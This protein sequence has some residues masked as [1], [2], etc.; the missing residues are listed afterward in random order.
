MSPIVFDTP[1]EGGG[2][3]APLTSAMPRPRTLLV[4]GLAALAACTGAA[5]D[6]AVAGFSRAE[7][8]TRAAADERPLCP[9]FASALP[10]DLR[11][12]VD[13][14]DYRRKVIAKTYVCGE[15][16][17]ATGNLL[18]LWRDPWTGLPYATITCAGVR[19]GGQAGVDPASGVIP[20]LAPA[21]I[22]VFAEDA[23]RA[24]TTVDW[25]FA[26]RA[27]DGTLPTL[28]WALRVTLRLDAGSGSGAS[29]RSG[30]IAWRAKADISRYAELRIRYR[31]SEAGARWRL[32]LASGLG[33]TVE[34]AVTLPGS[35]TWT[36]R[37]F[38]IAG[39]FA[40]T[41]ASHLNHVVFA[42]TLAD[43]GSNPTLWV[44]QV[45][46]IAAPQRAADCAIACPSPSPAYPDLACSEPQTSVA[47]IANALSFLATA[48]EGG[49]LDDDVAKGDVLRIL[50][51]LAVLPGGRPRGD[52]GGGWF[53]DL[54]SPASLMPDPRQRTTT[55]SAQ[56][57]LF[58]ALMVVESTWPDLARRAGALR[59]RMDWSSFYDGRGGCP[60]RLRS[61][62]DR[63]GGPTPDDEAV[64]RLGTDQVLGVFLAE[65]THAAPA[66]YWTSGLSHPA[67]DLHGPTDAPWYAASNVCADG[68]IP[69]SEGGGP[70]RSLAGLLYLQSDRIPTGGLALGASAANMLR[71]QYRFA[72]DN[73]LALAGWSDASDPDACAT[74]SCTGFVPEKVTAYPSAMAASDAFPETYAMLRAFHLLGADAWLNTGSDIISLGLHDGFDQASARA[75]DSYRY[76][77]TGFT[78]LGILNAC[79]DGLVRRRFAAH[80]VARAGYA[81]LQSAA[82]PCP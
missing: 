26:D 46:F 42:S 20:Q 2:V 70:F 47:D 27:P 8:P 62:L 51:S 12:R 81:V 32:A 28:L 14:G 82:P 10:E 23:G 44:D 49:L 5:P 39:D 80:R 15:L 79:R 50:D 55:I 6:A 67:C 34:R 36:D 63:C 60:G 56:A 75:R 73:G 3:R 25:D 19:A 21:D 71:A 7:Q 58:A 54:H 59:G 38:A 74:T 9:A 17:Q 22:T 68:A 53:Q 78:E 52:P 31:T 69:A 40:G 24:A 30:G 29:N 11:S 65:A 48:A 72:R 18:R 37:T 76:L 43:S 45:S 4:I 57:Q 13:D 1:F 66:C 35:T 33:Q 41:D 64:A 16:L 61:S 77:S